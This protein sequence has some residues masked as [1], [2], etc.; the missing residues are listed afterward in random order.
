VPKGIENGKADSM[1]FI[2]C[3]RSRDIPFGGTKPVRIVA[4]V[5][6]LR[7]TTL[8][9]SSRGTIDNPHRWMASTCTPQRLNNFAK[10][11]AE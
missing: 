11:P 7:S 10:L 9:T 4:A 8:R 2:P 3:S 1:F 5:F 6:A